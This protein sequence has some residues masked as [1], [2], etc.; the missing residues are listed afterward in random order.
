MTIKNV[1]L[2]SQQM[3]TGA[4]FDYNLNS[5]LIH[6]DIVLTSIFQLIYM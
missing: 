4:I 6:I 1:N 3:I 5:L 2:G